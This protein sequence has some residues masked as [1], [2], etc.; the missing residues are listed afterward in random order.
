M[1]TIITGKRCEGKTRKLVELASGDPNSIIVCYHPEAMKDKAMAYGHFVPTMG[2]E[3]FFSLKAMNDKFNFYLD[4]FDVYCDENNIPT[5]INSIEEYLKNATLYHV[6]A[7]T[8]T[9]GDK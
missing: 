8:F 2:Y 5:D 1:T 3:E 4:D 7:Y 6:A 9:I